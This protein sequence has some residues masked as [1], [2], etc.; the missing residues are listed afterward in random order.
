MFKKVDRKNLIKVL[1][2]GFS[3][4]ALFSGANMAFAT[5]SVQASSITVLKFK[6]NAYEYTKHGK[7]ANHKCLT[8]GSSYYSK[9]RRYIHGKKYY[10]ISDSGHR[11][12]IKSGNIKPILLSKTVKVTHNSYIYNRWGNR[13]FSQGTYRPGHYYLYGTRYIAGNKYYEIGDGMY[14]KGSNVAKPNHR[15]N[16]DTGYYISQKALKPYRTVYIDLNKDDPLYQT[17]Q[18]AINDWNATGAITFSLV[19]NKNQANI[20]IKTTNQPDQSWGG[21][22][23]YFDEDAKTKKGI[24]SERY[25]STINYNTAHNEHGGEKIVLEHELGHAIGLD[26]NHEQSIMNVDEG[27]NGDAVMFSFNTVQPADIANV[28]RMFDE[29]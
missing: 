17:A 28:K 3:S 6:A 18:E 21:Q 8:K 26:H 24:L 14:I 5:N 13:L 22:D 9:G 10:I 7:R 20:V 12:Y 2:L 16:T 25:H 15:N 1:A 4:A 23:V 29:N 19:N 11:F 27:S